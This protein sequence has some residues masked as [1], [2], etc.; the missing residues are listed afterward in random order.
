MN[1]LNFKLWIAE[2]AGPFVY[3]SMAGFN[4]LQNDTLCIPQ[5]GSTS[6]I[7]QCSFNHP[8]KAYVCTNED[9]R[10][11]FAGKIG[12]SVDSLIL[13]RKFVASMKLVIIKIWFCFRQIKYRPTAARVDEIVELA[14][15][16][17]VNPWVTKYFCELVQNRGVFV[18]GYS[19]R[20]LFWYLHEP[21]DESSAL[22]QALSSGC[23]QPEKEP[24]L[25]DDIQDW[26][27]RGCTAEPLG[28][29]R[30]RLVAIDA[31]RIKPVKRNTDGPL[32]PFL[33]DSNTA[34]LYEG[35][36]PAPEDDPNNTLTY[37]RDVHLGQMIMCLDYE[38]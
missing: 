13:V 12:V 27:S 21:M 6:K 26:Q 1:S 19:G 37:F 22:Q 7:K 38:L 35:I 4:H 20:I 23:T 8:D 17:R 30:F 24:I 36:V 2:G 11:I 34:I 9:Q 18:A 14:N 3:V 31:S 33:V 10:L 16:Q 32:V 15:A 28:K 29:P 25:C 5:A